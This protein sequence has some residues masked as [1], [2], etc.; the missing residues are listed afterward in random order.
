MLNF[1]LRL[2]QVKVSYPPTP[3]VMGRLNSSHK[4]LWE[5]MDRGLRSSEREMSKSHR[6]DRRQLQMRDWI[7][8]K[9]AIVE[10]GEGK[11]T[12]ARQITVTIV[13][14]DLGV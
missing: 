8:L 9:K 10:M 13:G 2:M 7:S 1:S 5:S 4:N 3:K 12:D 14:L 6:L 11:K